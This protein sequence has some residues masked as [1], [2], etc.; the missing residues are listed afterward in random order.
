M[1]ISGTASI[2]EWQQAATL[3]LERAA[4]S[5]DMRLSEPIQWMQD[6]AKTGSG[7]QAEDNQKWIL[8]QLRQLPGVSQVTLTWGTGPG[9]EIVR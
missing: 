5:M 3:R 7:Q 4:H 6:F 2:R 8:Q 1:S 9:N